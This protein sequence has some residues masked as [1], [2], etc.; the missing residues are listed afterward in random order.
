MQAQHVYW[1][2]FKDKQ[3]TLA[4][5]EATNHLSEK[6]IY[7]RKKF[8]IPFDQTDLP[9]DS[10]YKASV[11]KS[12]FQLIAQSKWLN[13]I[14]LVVP[15][16]SDIDSIQGYSFVNAITYMGIYKA[17][18]NKRPKEGIDIAEKKLISFDSTF[19]KGNPY[20]SLFYGKSFNQ[21]TQLKTNILHQ[22]GFTAKGVDI[23]L[24]DAG[25]AKADTMKLFNPLFRSGQLKYTYDFIE[26]NEMVVDDDE[27]GTAVLSI[28][29]G[30]LPNAYIGTAPMANYV[31]LRSEHA[32]IEMP[33]EELCWIEAIEF[34]DSLGI[35]LVNSSLGYNEFD[36]SR[37]NHFYKDLDGHSTF[38]SKAAQMAVQK[39]MVVCV[40]AGNEGD[41]AW[42]HIGVPADAKDV[43]AVGAVSDKGYLASFSSIGP[44][45]DKRI[46]PDFVAQGESIW[47]VSKNGNLYQ[48][49]GTSYACPLLAGSI[50]CLM[51]AFPLVSPQQLMQTLHLSSSKY[52]H[53]DNYLGY[54]IPDFELAYALLKADTSVA[55]IDI[56]MLTDKKLHLT[57]HIQEKT[58]Y[59]IQIA[60]ENNQLI[61]QFQ[62]H[63]DRIGINRVPIKR[64]RKWK[65][66][67]YMVTLQSK[68]NTLYYPIEIQ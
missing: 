59:T 6:S 56:R 17:S 50:A 22:K 18:K 58:N 42:K 11:S 20:D 46:K 14:A 41:D 66:G 8:H 40:S 62:T 13:A 3:T 27:H 39:G 60:D 34:A 37:F 19:N 38:I 9:I 48:G 15:N 26:Q 57:Y 61:S 16:K 28:M 54:G 23:A 45:A 44:T 67:K 1:V 32:D 68:K 36:D 24:I 43:I 55:I 21:L 47:V 33:I 49:N 4:N 7:R 63:L 52:N 2:T 10:L 29:A 30:Y 12:T 25:F 35:D 51:Q 5:F 65:K 31:L 64:F 53:P